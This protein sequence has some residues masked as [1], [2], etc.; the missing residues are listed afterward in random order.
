MVVLWSGRSEKPNHALQLLHIIDIIRFWAEYTYKPTIG[1]C[2]SRLQAIKTDGIPVPLRDT[3]WTSRITL[4]QLNTPWLFHQRSP[5]KA[6]S[7]C[8]ST[9]PANNRLRVPPGGRPS[10]RHSR[11]QLPLGNDTSLAS[12]PASRQRNHRD[13][14]PVG[15]RY[16]IPEI[17]SYN[18]VMDRDPGD[19]DLLLIRIDKNGKRRRPLIVFG[20]AGWDDPSFNS[21]LADEMQ[22]YPSEVLPTFTVDKKGRNY[23]WNCCRSKKFRYIKH[24]TQFC[25]ILPLDRTAYDQQL[26]KLK[27]SQLFEPLE[28]LFNIPVLLAEINHAYDKWCSCG[29]PWNEYSS[30]MIQ[31]NNA[32]CDLGWYHNRCVGLDDADDRDFWL[33]D[34]CCDIPDNERTDIPIEDLKEYNVIVEASSYRVQRTR[35]LIRAWNKHAWPNEEAVLREFQD[36]TRNLDVVK[37]AAYSISRSGVQRDMELPRYW[38]LSKDQPRHLVRASSRQRQLVYH[39]EVSNE[40]YES[41]SDDAE[42]DDMYAEE[43]AVDNIENALDS[44]SLSHARP[45]HAFNRFWSPS[46]RPRAHNNKPLPHSLFSKQQSSSRPRRGS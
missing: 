43:E 26:P 44:M 14:T 3:L 19:G 25:A 38:V 15:E 4:N 10:D 36:I 21:I 33:C 37:S 17:D 6:N 13:A 11:G 45:S 31:C 2:L 5:H 28:L 1:A 18:W 41:N 20:S 27:E 42:E 12:R 22:R 40:D 29:S 9:P 39:R 30:T 35:T 32:K 16:I 23:L 8:A 34:T 24:Q 46:P 7:V